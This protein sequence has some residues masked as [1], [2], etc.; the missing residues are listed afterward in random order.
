MLYDASFKRFAG[1]DP[2]LDPLSF[3]LF[4]ATALVI[5]ITPGPGLF[6]VAARTLSG[7]RSDGLAS[8]FGTGLGGLVHVVAGAFGVSA[9]VMASAEAF[10]ILKLVG[11]AYLVWL[12]IKT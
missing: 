6:Y 10:T 1:K 5:A 3:L 11:A 9:V 4:L 2:M 8:T 7:G 12:G